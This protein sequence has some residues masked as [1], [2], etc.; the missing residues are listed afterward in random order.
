MRDER[1]IPAPVAHHKNENAIVSNVVRSIF[2]PVD[3]RE[4]ASAATRTD[5]LAP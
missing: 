2:E 4:C 5:C 1:R 3:G